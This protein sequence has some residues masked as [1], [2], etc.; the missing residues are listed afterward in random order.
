M[1]MIF[2]FPRPPDSSDLD[3]YALNPYLAKTEMQ[4]VLRRTGVVL[5]NLADIDREGRVFL[6]PPKRSRFDFVKLMQDCQIE[7]GRRGLSGTLDLDAGELL[8]IPRPTFPERPIAARLLERY[9]PPAPPYVVRYTKYKYAEDLLSNGVLRINPAS[10]MQA[11]ALVAINDNEIERVTHFPCHQIRLHTPDGKILPLISDLTANSSSATDYYAL[12]FCDTLSA[13]M[14]EV[15]K[16]DC[17]ILLRDLNSVFGAITKAFEEQMPGGWFHGRDYV[18]YFD[19]IL[20]SRLSKGPDICFSKPFDFS[21]QRELR[22]CWLPEVGQ[23]K[24]QP[25]ELK[26]NIDPSWVEFW[27]LN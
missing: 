4:A 7:L 8:H 25:V 18:D 24:L 9:G 12:F 26:V 5:G 17:A 6:S 2:R 15:F 19:P 21:Y 13:K 27:H 3:R 1:E 23:P 11:N 16:Y 20:D 22:L 10:T 14:F